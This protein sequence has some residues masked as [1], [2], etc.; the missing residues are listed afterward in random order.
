MPGTGS[1]AAWHR[2]RSSI[3]SLARLPDTAAITVAAAVRMTPARATASSLCR[4]GDQETFPWPSARSTSAP[5]RAN[6]SWMP[7]AE[8]VSSRRQRSSSSHRRLNWLMPAWRARMFRLTGSSGSAGCHPA[9][10]RSLTTCPGSMGSGSPGGR[11]GARRRGSSGGE[12]RGEHGLQDVVAERL[13]LVHAPAAGHLRDRGGGGPAPWPQ[14]GV[15]AVGGEQFPVVDEVDDGLGGCPAGAGAALADHGAVLAGH[16][17]AVG[18]VCLAVTGAD[19]AQAVDALAGEPVQEP[20]SLAEAPAGG[21]NVNR[22]PVGPR[23]RGDRFV[24]RHEHCE[25]QLLG[26]Q[27]PSRVGDLREAEPADVRAHRDGKPGHV[28]EVPQVVVEQGPEGLVREREPGLPADVSAGEGRPGRVL[29]GKDET[30]HRVSSSGRSGSSP[31][32]PVTWRAAW[33]RTAGSKRPRTWPIRWEYGPN[34]AMN[35]AAGIC[36]HCREKNAF[37]RSRFTACRGTKTASGQSRQTH[38]LAGQGCPFGPCSPAIWSAQAA[39]NTSR[40][41][42]TSSASTV[43]S[44]PS[45]VT[46]CG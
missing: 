4:G 31:S 44:R 37:S 35:W 46:I 12:G 30:G 42:P 17:A 41:P 18:E 27:P 24:P 16:V 38:G 32:S 9:A 1:S 43:P 5:S 28:G 26:G 14:A 39:V 19:L 40:V 45:E 8:T 21:G 15:R 10:S 7:T 23:Q 11:E 3:S 22:G 29:E 25:D 34:T 13:R 20:G 6:I 33:S 2:V 36:C